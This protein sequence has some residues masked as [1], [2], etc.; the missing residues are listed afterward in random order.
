[1]VVEPREVEAEH[2]DIGLY[3]VTERNFKV[4]AERNWKKKIEG[5]EGGGRVRGSSEGKGRTG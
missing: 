3:T 5:K 2:N 1:M 4:W